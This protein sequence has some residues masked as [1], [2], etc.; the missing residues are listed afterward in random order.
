MIVH[1]YP[2]ITAKG[3]MNRYEKLYSMH[4]DILP[5]KADFYIFF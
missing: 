1:R 5:Q 3:S 2:F 4:A